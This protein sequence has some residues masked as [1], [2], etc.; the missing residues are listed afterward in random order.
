MSQVPSPSNKDSSTPE[1]ENEASVPQNPDG[2]PYASSLWDT[3]GNLFSRALGRDPLQDPGV[4]DKDL[5]ERTL[6]KKIQLEGIFRVSRHIPH[7]IRSRAAFM[8]NSN[9]NT[10]Q[11]FLWYPEPTGLVTDVVVSY[12]RMVEIPSPR[13][14]KKPTKSNAGR[15]EGKSEPE[16]E[17]ASWP[18]A[19]VKI[20]WHGLEDIKD[21]IEYDTRNGNTHTAKVWV[22]QR[23]FIYRII[24]W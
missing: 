2:L 18:E 10:V 5:F 16:E 13:R 11:V 4:S 9:D 12:G 24:F 21:V 23:V 20:V 14:R 8:E 22:S 17:S 15:S 7:S 6:L 3:L 19:V 1:G